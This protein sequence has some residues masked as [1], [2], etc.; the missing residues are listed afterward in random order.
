VLAKV[1]FRYLADDALASLLDTFA[2]NPLLIN[3][4]ARN[5]HTIY[6]DKQSLKQARNSL[7]KLKSR[8]SGGVLQDTF[9]DN[10]PMTLLF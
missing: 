3:I 7:E 4:Y 5:F 6:L 9:A 1:N 10:S 2:V 8:T